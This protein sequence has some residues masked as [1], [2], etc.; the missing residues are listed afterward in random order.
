MRSR[1]RIYLILGVTFATAIG[2]A[3]LTG[4]GRSDTPAGAAPP[5]QPAPRPGD[6]VHPIESIHSIDRIHIERTL[7]RATE[8]VVE[9][10][11]RTAR[12]PVRLSPE[13][14][15]PPLISRTRRV[16]FGSGR[17]RPQPFP[18]V[19]LEDAPER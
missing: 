3:V 11:V 5:E 10:P 12:A 14:V 17:Y 1:P 15:A 16:L 4:R 13:P 6:R 18:H 19:T 7:V 2:T 8:Q 9:R